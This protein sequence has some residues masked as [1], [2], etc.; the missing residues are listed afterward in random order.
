MDLSEGIQDSEKGWLSG[1]TVKRRRQNI[2]Y[3]NASPDT[4]FLK[5]ILFQAEPTKYVSI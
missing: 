4:F 2:R 1:K 5:F 3:W